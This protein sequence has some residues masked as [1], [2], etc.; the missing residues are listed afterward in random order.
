MTLVEANA[1]RTQTVWKGLLKTGKNLTP[2]VVMVGSLTP[3]NTACLTILV[4]NM[5]FVVEPSMFV[6]VSCTVAMV[7]E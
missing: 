7:F 2:N 4:G 5:M 6:K 1:I 3:T